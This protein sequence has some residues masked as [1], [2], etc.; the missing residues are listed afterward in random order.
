MPAA[1]PLQP[2]ERHIIE[3]VLRFANLKRVDYARMLRCFDAVKAEADLRKVDP[4]SGQLVPGD[5][6]QEPNFGPPELGLRD[7]SAE[8]AQTVARMWLGQITSRKLRDVARD[9]GS[10]LPGNVT[11]AVSFEGRRLRLSYRVSKINGM[12]ALGI[13]F[14][15]DEGR[16]LT[17]RLKQCGYSKCG[18]FN[19]DLTPNGRPRRFCNEEHARRYSNEDSKNRQKRFRDKHQPKE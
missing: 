6:W 15:L 9:I 19:L 2:N 3:A 12:L 13:A 14:L 8:N 16:G 17:N 11:G 4:F 1:F 5:T 7:R 18:R 10:F